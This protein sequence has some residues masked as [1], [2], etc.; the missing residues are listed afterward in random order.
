MMPDTDLVALRA[1]RPVTVAHRGGLVYIAVHDEY[2]L[3]TKRDWKQRLKLAHPDM[4]P[5]RKHKVLV[6]ACD[7]VAHT[8][9]SGA[10][11]PYRIEAHPRRPF[12]AYRLLPSP[13][14]QFRLLHQSYERWL[15]DE[16]KWY[17]QFGLTVPQW[18]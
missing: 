11:R 10:G 12:W 7:I 17:A 14:R 5:I 3:Q 8:N 9:H 1:G 15:A 13:T 18:N 4:N 6:P 16:A 2:F